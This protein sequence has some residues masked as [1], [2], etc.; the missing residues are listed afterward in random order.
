VSLHHH[1]SEKMEDS[2]E[3]TLELQNHRNTEEEARERQQLDRLFE[4]HQFWLDVNETSIPLIR[5]HIDYFVDLSRGNDT[6]Q[7]VSLSP[8]SL[9]GQDNEFWDKVGQAVGN[10]KALSWIYLSR[11][12]V[13][14]QYAD[15]E[16]PIPDWTIL[17]CILSHVR[18]KIAMNYI[19]SVASGVEESR[20]FAR[21]IHGHPTIT[22]FEGGNR[23]PYECLGALYSALA[24][25]PALESIAL[26]NRDVPTPDDESVFANPE[27]LTELLRVPSLRSVRFFGFYFTRALCHATANALME[28]TAITK[29]DCNGC[30]YASEESAAIMANGLARNT[31]LVSI[32]TSGP[33][34]AVLIAALAMALPSNSTLREFYVWNDSDVGI[35]ISSAHLSPVFLALGKNTGLKS[36]VIKVCES[37]D[38]SLCTAIQNGLA[39]NETLESLELKYIPLFD[40]NVNLWYRALS[41]LRSNK[42]LKSLVV[43]MPEDCLESCLSALRIDIV[44]M[45]QDNKSLEML[46]VQS[47]NACTITIGDFFALA[48]TLQ[49][50]TK[51]KALKFSRII[52]VPLTDDQSKHIASLL[53]KNYALQ[54]LENIDANQAR[55][56]GA[57]LQLNEAGRR[58][59]IEDGSSISKGVEVLSRVSDDINCVFLHLLEN[60]RLCDRRAVEIIDTAG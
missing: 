15:D 25:L 52:K 4:V 46:T 22:C 24:T 33:V 13:E 50:N 29:L 60:P 37:M 47:W 27:S 39:L 1:S 8:P 28:G 12:N 18:Q 41:F 7:N 57:I 5:K 23:F 38:E 20:S 9:V 6:L 31:S 49:H 21:A 11:G 45:L 53:K 10:L 36:L 44:A 19:A 30:S 59:L 26:S 48:A 32:S 14:Y 3:T 34:D 2:S 42:A 54:N 40:D 58:Y 35:R 16:V 56:V 55:D 17:A 43:S 51:L